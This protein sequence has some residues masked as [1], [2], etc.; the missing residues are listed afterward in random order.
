MDH[1]TEDSTGSA[2]E[3]PDPSSALGSALSKIKATLK[4]AVPT[5]APSEKASTLVQTP[6]QRKAFIRF[7]ETIL[8]TAAFMI[9]VWLH[10]DI[11]HVYELEKIMHSIQERQHG[12]Y[13]HTFSDV[14]NMAE[15][16]EWTQNALL[17]SVIQ[18]TDAVS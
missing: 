11:T 13:G 9:L 8:F 12:T 15:V 10:E 1:S 17:P 16:W 7:V 6:R 2:P 3:K 18:N 4:A 14:S 5:K